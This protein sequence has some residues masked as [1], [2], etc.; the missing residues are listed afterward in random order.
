MNK[1]RKKESEEYIW[2]S[3]DMG[4]LKLSSMNN[5]WLKKN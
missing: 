4:Q 5:L 1:I 3:E 2:Y